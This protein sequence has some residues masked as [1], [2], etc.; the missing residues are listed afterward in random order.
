MVEKAALLAAL[1]DTYAELRRYAD[2]LTESERATSGTEQVW[3]PRD[4]LVHICEWERRIAHRLT[5]PR[6]EPAAEGDDDNITN[7]EIFHQYEQQPWEGVRAL[8]DQGSQDLIAQAERLDEETLNDPKAFDWLGDNNNPL[9]REIAGTGFLHPLAHLAGVYIQRGDQA[10]MARLI[11][12]Q[13]QHTR[14][15]DSSPD[16]QGTA[17]YNNGCYYAL[18]GQREEAL[19][20]V[21]EALRL[22]P[23][24]ADWA[25]KDT[26]LVS[27]HNDPDF[28]ALLARVKPSRETS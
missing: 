2:Q 7:A 5:R 28:Q 21:E 24:L 3:A 19:R 13:D 26:D 4:A 10:S 9:W 23:A 16:W 18:M 12:L 14:A 11:A 25:P 17:L 22:N 15:L 8:M 27:L 6:D 1:R 20:A